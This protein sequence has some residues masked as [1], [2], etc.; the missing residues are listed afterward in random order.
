MN[1]LILIAAAAGSTALSTEAGDLRHLLDKY[2]DEQ[3]ALAA[4]NAGQQNVDTWRREG[5]GIAFAETR[6]YVS[7]VEH[8]KTLYRR[9][10]GDQLHAAG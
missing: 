9:G 4:Y 2:G 5:K 6:H 8:L 7:R 10:Y 3:T 1:V